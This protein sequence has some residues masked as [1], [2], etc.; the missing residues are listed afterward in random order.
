MKKHIIN[1]ILF[2]FIALTAIAQENITKNV[3]D[4]SELKVFDGIS[5]RLIKSTESKAV[6]SGEDANKVTMVNKNGELKIRM[7]IKKVFNGYK[8]YIDLYYNKMIDVIDV[9]E[10]AFVSSPDTIQQVTL[11]LKTQEGAE[12]DIPVDV[13]KLDIKAVTGGI[14]ETKG[15]AKSQTIS[16][17]TGG[18]YNGEKLESGQADISINA[19]GA[20]TIKAID[21]LKA[22]VKA[23]G[24]VTIIG[25]PKVIDQQTFLG[26]KIIEQ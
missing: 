14:V 7:S 11:E 19:G 22:R 18:H 2:C 24:T 3:G 26:G 6:I 15:K 23:G 12:V 17:R 4:F 1:S 8:T 21:Y 9:N 16:I 20:A 10:S 25:K 5:V 13:D